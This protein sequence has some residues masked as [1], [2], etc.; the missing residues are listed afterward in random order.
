VKRKKLSRPKQSKSQGATP[1]PTR[2]GPLSRAFDLLAGMP[3]DFEIDPRE[4]DLPQKRRG[5]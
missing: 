2:R 1:H 5:L 4:K 3:E